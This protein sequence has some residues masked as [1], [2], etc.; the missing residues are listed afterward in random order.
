MKLGTMFQ[1]TE[2]SSGEFLQQSKSTNYLYCCTVQFEDSLNITHIPPC[3]GT[4]HTNTWYAA[5]SLIIT[6]YS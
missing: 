3:T 4:M 6:K 2:P 1:F 5:T